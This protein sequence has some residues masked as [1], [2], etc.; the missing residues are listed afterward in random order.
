MGNDFNEKNIENQTV[1]TENIIS[2]QGSVFS[3]EADIN[4]MKV[5]NN[6]EK[7]KTEQPAVKS[8]ASIK[9]KGMKMTGKMLTLISLMIAALLVAV[10]IVVTV[11][12]KSN[13]ELFV[14][15]W[16]Q[17]TSYAVNNYYNSM[18]TADYTYSE[19]EGL[20]KGTIALAGQTDF[21]DSLREDLGVY[22]LLFYGKK[23]YV[24]SV[25]INEDDS[26]HPDELYADTNRY[27]DAEVT[28]ELNDAMAN[29]E[30]YFT[31]GYDIGGQEYYGYFTPIEGSNGKV[32]G[33][34]F[35]GVKEEIVD[36]QVT[37]AIATTIIT[38]VVIAAI[39]LTFAVAIVGRIVKSIK[40]SV[41]GINRLAQG[42]LNVKIT[43]KLRRRNDEAGD[44]AHS[45]QKVIK[46]LKEI[47]QKIIVASDSLAKFTED[48]TKSFENITGTIEN[49][50]IAV[51]EIANG[52]TSQANES[53]NANDEVMNMGNA[54]D[55]TSE[56]VDMLGKSSDIMKNYS[57]KA[58]GTLSE[59]I[60]ITEETRKSIN[61]VQ[62]QTNL[63]NQS[64]MD[65]Q[66]ATALI[67][68]I[69]SQTNLLSLNASIEAARAGENGRGF[70]VVA[71]EIRNLADQSAVSA[72]RIAG[73]VDTL[74]AN[75]NVSVETMDD[76]MKDINTQNVKL[77]DTRSMFASL[78]GEI[79]SVT[80]AIGDI[81]VEMEQL[82]QIKSV[83]LQSVEAVA[84]IAQENAA[85]TEETSAS[86]EELTQIV[87]RCAESTNEL[88]ELSRELDESTKIFTL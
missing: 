43:K 68:D 1:E 54:I 56:N 49:V 12:V 66:E 22:T 48:F 78:T 4:E 42:N 81:R 63:T 35:C 55:K 72:D 86:M 59:L 71:N 23:A 24:S 28:D 62:K 58:G 87:D 21:I 52:A 45:V 26:L 33:I 16:L 39:A 30:G 17:S 38:I 79:A 18:S 46:S 41:D 88:I 77:E 2:E 10:A 3:E 37:S 85:S 25:L 83:V 64:A 50:N 13:S 20:K 9:R 36:E 32:I 80:Q 75:S 8:I 6:P 40:Y 31:G 65:I 44:I 5:E 57:D 15:N 51:D 69:A 11:N 19:A 60:K 7:E 84:A 76:V 14:E 73:I 29:A 67:A 70:A 53:Q 47:V 82:N 34:M 61:A 74:I 27:Y